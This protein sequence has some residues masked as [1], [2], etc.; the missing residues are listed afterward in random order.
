[1]K[2]IFSIFSTFL[3]TGNVYTFFNISVSHKN[4][5]N[6]KVP[7]QNDLDKNAGY[8][9][10]M[11][12][13][14]LPNIWHAP[15]FPFGLY[16]WKLFQHVPGTFHEN[17]HIDSDTKQSLLKH[18][19]RISYSS[20]NIWRDRLSLHLFIVPILGG[21]EKLRSVPGLTGRFVSKAMLGSPCHRRRGHSASRG[22]YWNVVAFQPLAREVRRCGP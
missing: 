19:S 21:K 11:Y 4:M 17:V 6:V 16:A 1:V 18:S 7:L 20:D 3:H 14:I 9:S 12:K 5:K 2:R 15:K 10:K 8:E 13:R 22:I